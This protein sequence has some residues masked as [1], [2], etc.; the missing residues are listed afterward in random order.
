VRV[1]TSVIGRV[2][3]LLATVLLA[4]GCLTAHDVLVGPTWTLTQVRGASP[5]APAS[6]SFAG[7]GT[8]RLTTGCND[9]GGGYHL[10]GNRIALDSVSLSAHD[11]PG[12]IGDEEVAMLAV[13]EGLPVY[14]IDTGT[15]NL[16]L[17]GDAGEVLLFRP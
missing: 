14:A 9:G 1:P 13:L 3:A 7:D 10:A 2:A 8:F 11:C 15:G 17:T 16:R 6:V 5:A 12:A 4:A